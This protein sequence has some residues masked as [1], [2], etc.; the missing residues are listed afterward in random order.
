MSRWSVH[1]PDRQAPPPEPFTFAMSFGRAK[2]ALG[3]SAEV[4]VHLNG[5]KGCL[6]KG[7][8]IQR[9]QDRIIFSDAKSVK[10]TRG[11]RSTTD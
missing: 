3:A 7:K 4:P 9:E 11:A 8:V 5:T 6:E 1:I 10:A 2:L